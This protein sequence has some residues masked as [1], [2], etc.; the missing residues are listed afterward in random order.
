MQTFLKITFISKF[1]FANKARSHNKITLQSA[2]SFNHY[3]G[4]H[5]FLFLFQDQMD[6]VSLDMDREATMIGMISERK[7]KSSWKS[8]SIELC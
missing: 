6:Q 5:P 1:Y 4:V 8:K 3:K 7:L 2:I